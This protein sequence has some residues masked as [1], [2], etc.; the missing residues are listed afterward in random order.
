MRF[1]ERGMDMR[2]VF[3]VLADDFL[4]I[5]KRQFD[6]EGGYAS[7][8]W[9]PLTEAYLRR[10]IQ[11]G[12]DHRILHRTLAM[13]RSLTV[14]GAPGQVRR[15][16]RDTLEVGTAVRSNKGFPYPAVHQRPLRSPLPRR[17]PVE[18]RETDRDRWVK[19]MQRYLV[20]GLVR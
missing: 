14:R 7:G 16:T 2:P 5:E 6:S 3:H 18:L 17:R 10:K 11:Q 9:K 20:T 8:G 13:R 19:M 12:Y 15:I 4:K 1:R